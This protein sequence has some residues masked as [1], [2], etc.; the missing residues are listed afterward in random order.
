MLTILWFCG[1]DWLA[2]VAHTYWLGHVPLALVVGAEMIFWA[3]IA[4]KSLFG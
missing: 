2:A 4:R 1:D 3:I